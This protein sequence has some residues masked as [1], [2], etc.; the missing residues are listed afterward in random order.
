[1]KRNDLSGY[2]MIDKISGVYGP[3][4]GQDKGSSLAPPQGGRGR[5]RVQPFSRA[6]PSLR[7]AQEDPEREQL[8]EDFRRRI[9]E[10]TYSPDLNR[11]ARAL[12]NAGLLEGED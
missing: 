1:M 4:V 9:A 6:S 11:V 12:I 5:R 2:D 10:G 3:G 7:G 8:V